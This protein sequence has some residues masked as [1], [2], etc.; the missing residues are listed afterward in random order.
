MPCRPMRSRRTT[1]LENVTKEVEDE[2]LLK[3]F[4]EMSTE[5]KIVKETTRNMM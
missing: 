5:R 4:T 2:V 1:K 3:K